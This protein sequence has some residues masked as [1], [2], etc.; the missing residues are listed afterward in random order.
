M[1]RIPGYS[2]AGPNGG[3]TNGGLSNGGYGAPTDDNGRRPS[4][5]RP[6]RPGGYGGMNAPADDY[7]AIA[8]ES[9]GL[10]DMGVAPSVL[11]RTTTHGHQ[12]VTG[13]ADRAAMEACSSLKRMPPK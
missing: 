11:E 3:Y 8:S 12:A 7:P 9:A 1:S 4:G 5:E 10:A 13:P 6:Q 2:R